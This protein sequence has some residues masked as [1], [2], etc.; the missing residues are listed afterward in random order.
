ML[1]DLLRLFSV[2]FWGVCLVTFII[3][4]LEVNVAENRPLYGY[5]ATKGYGILPDATLTPGAVNPDITQAN[6]KDTL[7]NPAWSTKSIRPSPSYTSKLK[8]KQIRQ[9]GYGDSH[10][11][12]YEEDHLISLVLGGH[13]T[14]PKNLWP[15]SYKTVPNA[16][17]KDS[18]EN[19]LH[20]ELCAGTI[21]LAEAQR[22][23]STDWVSVYN[24]TLKNKFGA[25]N[26]EVD[27]DDI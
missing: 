7:C 25:T 21:T 27:L 5:S 26:D 9:Y 19:L 3:Y 16:R 1:R 20:R 18:V 15:Q 23:I 24:A 6:I 22:Q 8:I 10:S 13:P 11:M 12:D 2:L 14:D 4:R 17:N